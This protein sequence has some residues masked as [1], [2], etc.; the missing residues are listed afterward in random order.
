MF[1]CRQSQQCTTCCF[2]NLCNRKNRPSKILHQKHTKHNCRNPIVKF[3]INQLSIK[4]SN[5]TRSALQSQT[6]V[7]LLIF[8]FSSTKSLSWIIVAKHSKSMEL[9]KSI[10][11]KWGPYITTCTKNGK[12]YGDILHGQ[13]CCTPSNNSCIYRNNTQT[14]Q[15]TC[16][17]ML[18][19]SDSA[20]WDKLYI[21]CF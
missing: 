16:L 15:Y 6:H 14:L 8:C 18:M 1:C 7:N 12:K 4:R 3:D 10:F 20:R 9:P 21:L 17:V 2:K 11:R 5:L 13:H 19:S